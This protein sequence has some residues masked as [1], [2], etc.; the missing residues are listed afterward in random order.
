[1]TPEEYQRAFG[2]GK[3]PARKRRGAP[4]MAARA[5]D[6]AKRDR[7][8]ASW[9]VADETVN[10]SLLRG[11]RVMRARSRDFARNNEYGRKFFSLVRTNVVGADGFSLK[12]NCLDSLGKQDKEDSAL[13]EAAYGRHGKAGEYDVTG[14]LTEAAFDA[15]AVNMIAR[16]GEVL[17]RAVP[18][19]DRGKHRFQLQLLPGHLLDEEHNKELAGGYRIRMGVEFDPFMKPVAYH[20]RTGNG[21]S[22]MY[23]HQGSRRYERVPADEMLHLFIP[24]EIEQWRG[25]PWLFAALRSAQHLD[26]FD[27][28]AL[29]AANVGAS[30]MGFFKRT[31]PDA[32][33]ITGGEQQE[34]S[35]GQPEFVQSAEPGSFEMLPDG[36]DLANWDPEYPNGIYEQFHKAVLRRT[37]AGTLVSYH[38]LS[39]DLT[40]V[41]FSSIRSGTLDEREMWKTIQ[42]WYA[43]TAKV[44]IFEQWLARALINDSALIEAKLPFAKFEKFN[45]PIFQGRRWDWVSPKDDAV[46]KR[47]EVG[48]GINSRSQIIRD[49]GGDPGKVFQELRDEEEIWGFVPPKSG[50]AAPAAKPDDDQADS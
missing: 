12:V 8:T 9:T 47:E 43:G 18:G 25:A 11:L 29:V 13:I 38:S 42:G 46:A 37:A 14:K 2:A 50:N 21:A 15:M 6:S 27:E 4:R 31:D 28:A 49:R 10:Q 17:I 20:L 5:F 32:G 24:E 1:M 39:G 36:W 26:Q 40:D 33:D 44:W 48:L 41:N 35:D 34:G 3:R 22:D 23:A 7:L 19:R 45:A 30:K 16:D